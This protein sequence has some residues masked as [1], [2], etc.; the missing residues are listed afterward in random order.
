MMESQYQEAR[1]NPSFRQ[2]FLDGIDLGAYAE[3]VSRVRYAPQGSFLEEGLK[4]T[5]GMANLQFNPFG[6]FLKGFR[7]LIAVDKRPFDIFENPYD[8]LNVLLHHEGEHARQRFESPRFVMKKR[9][10][11]EVRAWQNQL[12]NLDQRCSFGYKEAVAAQAIKLTF[13]SLR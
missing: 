4:A 7:S 3:Y 11:A 12:R 9:G 6:W 2:E 8:F 1:R 10:L 5:G 13:E